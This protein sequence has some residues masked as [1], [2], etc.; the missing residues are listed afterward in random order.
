[1]KIT[2]QL[3]LFSQ[4]LSYFTQIEEIQVEEVLLILF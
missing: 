3:Q 1:M 2:L 4:S